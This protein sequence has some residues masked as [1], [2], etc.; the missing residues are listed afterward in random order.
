VRGQTAGSGYGTAFWLSR[1]EIGSNNAAVR[2]VIFGD[3]GW[4]GSRDAWSQVG[5]PMSGVGVGASFLDGMI[6]M[7]LARGLYPRLQTR[8]DLSLEARF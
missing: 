3:L 5:R 1:V 6:R 7:D 8:F 2:P 4:A